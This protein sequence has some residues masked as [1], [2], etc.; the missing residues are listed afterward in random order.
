[1]LSRWKISFFS[2][3]SSCHTFYAMHCKKNTTT[4]ALKTAFHISKYQYN[5]CNQIFVN[6]KDSNKSSYSHKHTFIGIGVF[7]SFVMNA[8]PNLST[9]QSRMSF[10]TTIAIV[11]QFDC[12]RAWMFVC[13]QWALCSLICLGKSHII[14]L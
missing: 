7:L 2:N 12:H 14:L 1:M 11:K 10:T 8:K 3:H 4:T 13:V 9:L 5:L 6:V